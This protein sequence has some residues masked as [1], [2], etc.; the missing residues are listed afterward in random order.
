MPVDRNHAFAMGTTCPIRPASA[1]PLTWLLRA[2]ATVLRSF[3]RVR[4]RQAAE[5]FLQN[6]VVGSDCQVGPH[7]WCFNPGA[8]QNVSLG[9][10]VVCRGILRSESFQPGTIRIADYV[11]IGDDCIISCAS[12][13][14]IGRLTLLA[15]GVQIFDNDSHPAASD[16]REQ[17]YLTVLGRRQGPRPPI[18]SAPVWIG[19]RA[20]LG[21][22]A[23]VMKGVR[24]GDGSIVA[25]GSVVTTD[26]SPYTV[27]AG[28]PAKVVKE[29]MPIQ[30]PREPQQET[31]V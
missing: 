11:Y 22:G 7:A 3:D 30:P 5:S 8:K 13:I 15:H 23:M 12:E 29:L 4:C 6:A 27:V 2:M 20:W 9:D 18:A 1:S 26:V 16:A 28:N 19:E 17:D 31:D 24:I 21:C 25:A 10:Y 14:E